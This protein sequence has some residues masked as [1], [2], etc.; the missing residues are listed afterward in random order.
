MYIDI[1]IGVKEN[2]KKYILLMLLCITGC[3]HMNWS[4]ENE[5]TFRNS[6][7]A[8]ESNTDNIVYDNIGNL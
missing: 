1:L 6:L 4:V 2:M 7:D 8:C 5:C 3:T